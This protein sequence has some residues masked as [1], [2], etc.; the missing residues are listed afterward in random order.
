ME[1]NEKISFNVGDKTVTEVPSDLVERARRTEDTVAITGAKGH[2]SLAA[3]GAL[4]GILF[5]GVFLA[6]VFLAMP[7]LLPIFPALGCVATFLTASI[8][9]TALCTVGAFLVGMFA[10]SAIHRAIYPYACKLAESPETN[11]PEPPKNED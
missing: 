9:H 8:L 3:V 10:C 11:L 7:Y 2:W 1:D 6:C 5:A 4:S